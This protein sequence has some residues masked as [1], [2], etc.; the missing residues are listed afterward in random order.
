MLE[1]R[2]GRC[3]KSKLAFVLLTALAS[4]L[5]AALL[6]TTLLSALPA[7]ILL[8]LV[9][10]LTRLFLLVWGGFNSASLHLFLLRAL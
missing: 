6:T 8:V 1:Q 2:R 5:L 3:S 7:L 4:T 10:V 9:L